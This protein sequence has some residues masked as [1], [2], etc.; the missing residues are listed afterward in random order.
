MQNTR[1]FDLNFRSQVSDWNRR[2]KY[3]L[4]EVNILVY[5]SLLDTNS[6]KKP[7]NYLMIAGV[8]DRLQRLKQ[9]TYARVRNR[10]V[11]SGRSTSLK[12]FRLSRI[13]FRSLAGSGK[14]TGVSKRLNK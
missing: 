10:C 1:F 9:N 12:K 4:K 5:K 7:E 6:C 14:L 2:K 13:A 11:I 3:F 8:E